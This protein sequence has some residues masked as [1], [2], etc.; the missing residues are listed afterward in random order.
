[1]LK[2]KGLGLGLA[3]ARRLVEMHWGTVGIESQLSEGTTAWFTLP[4]DDIQRESAPLDRST[5]DQLQA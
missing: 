5:T 1:M 2:A 3:I 4:C